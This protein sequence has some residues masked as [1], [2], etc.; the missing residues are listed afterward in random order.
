MHAR[1]KVKSIIKSIDY[2]YISYI[3]MMILV[4]ILFQWLTKFKS[5][6][7]KATVLAKVCIKKT[8]TKKFNM[9]SCLSNLK[10][11]GISLRCSEQ[12]VHLSQSFALQLRFACAHR[13]PFTV[14][15]SIPFSVRSPFTHR[16]LCVRSPIVRSVLTLHVRKYVSGTV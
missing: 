8:H 12:I 13:S 14:A 7:L 11:R 4:L 5:I 15:H 1:V 2:V 6:K 10:S 9:Y 3:I 16:V